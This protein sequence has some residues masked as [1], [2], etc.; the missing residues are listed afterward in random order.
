MAVTVS[1]FRG[2]FPEFFDGNLYPDPQID[3][4]IEM[5]GLLM[6]GRWPDSHPNGE[7]R[8]I[9]DFGIELFI[10]HNIVLERQAQATAARGGTP[11]ISRGPISSEAAGGAS[12]SYDT[13]SGLNPED[14][15]WNL[16][17]YGTRLM[18][19]VKLI[20]MGPIQVGFG[21]GPSYA[22]GGGGWFGPG[23]GW[24]YGESW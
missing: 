15:H 3:F 18:S 20:G 19:L 17:T 12:V 4:W 5:A 22:S 2:D 16:T 1:D 7:R 10:A 13:T 14:G 6:G 8:S 9:R 23:G 11:G 21:F 24:R